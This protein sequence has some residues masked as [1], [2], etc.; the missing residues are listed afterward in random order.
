MFLALPVP[1]SSHAERTVVF[2]GSSIT[3][4]QGE[5]SVIQLGNAAITFTQLKPSALR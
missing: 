1:N 4:C 5:P 2:S 3:T